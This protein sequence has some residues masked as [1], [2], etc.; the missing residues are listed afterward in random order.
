MTKFILAQ[1]NTKWRFSDRAFREH[2]NTRRI[3]WIS[4]VCRL[5]LVRKK[6]VVYV[7]LL[8]YNNGSNRGYTHHNCSACSCTYL[9]QIQTL[10]AALLLVA[11]ILLIVPQVTT[12]ICNKWCYTSLRAISSPA[13]FSRFFSGR[14]HLLLLTPSQS[15]PTQNWVGGCTGF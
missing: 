6:Y 11:Q 1:S 15:L 2:V 14:R 5:P 9:Y 3:E 13:V 8:F 7:A 10:L 4:E 12:I